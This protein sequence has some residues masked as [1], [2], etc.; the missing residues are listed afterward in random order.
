[1]IT[2]EQAQV[3]HDRLMWDG[4]I[5]PYNVLD[6]PANGHDLQVALMLACQKVVK[7]TLIVMPWPMVDVLKRFQ[8]ERFGYDF[9]KWY[10]CVPKRSEYPVLP[11]LGPLGYSLWGYV[12][13]FM[14]IDVL[15]NHMAENAWVTNVG[16]FTK[17]TGENTWFVRMEPN[18]VT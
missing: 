13:T 9:D 7:P 4:R 10:L 17:S 3:I 1:M 2:F 5:D 6:T 8:K 18:P 11:R 16:D 15:A 14:G 12:G